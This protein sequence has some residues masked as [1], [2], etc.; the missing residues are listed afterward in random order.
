MRGLRYAATSASTIIAGYLMQIPP[1]MKDGLLSLNE[2]AWLSLK[3][4][5]AL[6]F[7]PILASVY[8]F[9]HY[10]V[11][12]PRSE[13]AERLANPIGEFAQS[14]AKRLFPY[15]ILLP[16]A[17]IAIYH[18]SRSGSVSYKLVISLGI[19]VGLFLFYAR[20]LANYKTD[21]TDPLIRHWLISPVLLSIAIG[22]FYGLSFS[23]L[24]TSFQPL[25][26]VILIVAVF[27][28]SLRFSKRK[29]L[30]LYLAVL[31]V[32]T[33]AAVLN[34]AEYLYLSPKLGLSS[35]LFCIAASVYLAVFEAASITSDIARDDQ[36]DPRP[37]RYAQATL[38][39]L[40]AT[41][42]LFP[43]YYIFSSYGSAFLIGF[44]L[45]AFTTFIV[46]FYWGKPPHLTW[47]W[48][49]IKLLPGLVFLAL[50]VLAPTSFFS[51]QWS[52]Q[53]LERFPN[54][55]FGV[56][57]AFVAPLVT[58][59][60]KAF[61][62]VRDTEVK[63]PITELFKD[64]INFTRIL[65]F[66]CF[67]LCCAIALRLPFVDPT[68]P[69]YSRAQLACL[70]YM[71]CVLLCP[72][73]EI[74]ELLRPKGKVSQA[75]KNVA[76]ILL[77]IRGFTSTLIGLA[78]FLPLYL[79]GSDA[80]TAL[81]A[82]LPFF[83]AASGGFALNDYYDL[84]KDRINKPYRAIPS[85][86][87]TANFAFTFGIVLLS[88]AVLISFFVYRNNA[89]LLIYL[90]SI[91]GAG[92]YSLV[93]KYLSLSKTI[94]TAAISVLPMIYVIDALSYP[95]AYFLIPV[96]GLFF[97]LGRELLMDIRDMVGDRLSQ[98]TTLPM[99]M[100]S[101]LTALIA[102]LLLGVSGS[103]LVLFSLKVWSL[104]NVSMTGVILSSS[105][106]LPYPWSY[107][108]GKYRRLVIISLYVPILC[109]IILMVR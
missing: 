61:V 19:L 53:Y 42:W 22:L 97:L 45:H 62:E 72:L 93:V 31:F 9:I 103:I 7:I 28:V 46:W 2:R 11:R 16:Y 104:R 26:P 91:A 87:L 30:L 63:A 77:I 84:P 34:K 90:V 83:L 57:A 38:V 56:L 92:L 55:A 59:M 67:I 98:M 25:V 58:L 6:L 73:M 52:F 44:A 41:V 88:L 36:T 20:F 4:D 99:V 86:K 85:G 64:R 47:R 108:G 14:Q 95:P 51:K 33:T 66:L 8:F 27:L 1:E 29:F 35:I 78:V 65:S 109:G 32:L 69:S 37:P 79:A 106:L 13:F 94:L 18:V 24:K 49:D 10:A 75:V 101:R 40:T 89:Q 54:W 68:L 100:G 80:T 107:N 15:V 70:V 81:Y 74:R 17:V 60:L 50:L 12:F 76:G 96:G 43:F 82:S 5:I 3:N 48:S 102:F 21:G 71:I 23:D 39:A 105:F